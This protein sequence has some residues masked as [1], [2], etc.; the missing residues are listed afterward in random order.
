M[1]C[2]K[3]Y[4]NIRKHKHVTNHQKIKKEE[5]KIFNNFVQIIIYI[6]FGIYV[7]VC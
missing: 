4:K 3:Y 5:K 1:I 6:I 7:C 2:E